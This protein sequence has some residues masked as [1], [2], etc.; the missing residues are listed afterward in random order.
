MVDG[1][2]GFDDWEGPRFHL[3]VSSRASGSG[4]GADEQS[5]LVVG[6]EDTLH[7]ARR[8]HSLRLTRLRRA[9]GGGDAGGIEVEVTE[10]GD[11]G[12]RSA[13]EGRDAG[14]GDISIRQYGVEKPDT[15]TLDCLRRGGVAGPAE[16]SA[17]DRRRC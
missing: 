1:K 11:A 2:W 4:I 13:A 5:A 9:A 12:S 8:K 15:V 10:A 16:L 17:G 7:V 14:D 3:S 6:R